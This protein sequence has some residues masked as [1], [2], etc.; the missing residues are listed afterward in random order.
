[1]RTDMLR[2]GWSLN[3]PNAKFRYWKCNSYQIK[4]EMNK[5]GNYCLKC[6]GDISA[7]N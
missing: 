2:G 4:K 1:M 5:I 7:D 6:Y 3:S